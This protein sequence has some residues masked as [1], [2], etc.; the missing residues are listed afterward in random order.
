MKKKLISALCVSLA[1]VLLLTVVLFRLRK[2]YLYVNR[3]RVIVL[4]YQT[5]IGGSDAEGWAAFLEKN[6]PALPGVEVGVYRRLATGNENVTIVSEDG[7]QAIVTRLAAGQGDLLLVNNQV[8][9]ETLVPGEYLSEL[10]DVFGTRG[11]RVD[12]RLVGVDVTDQTVEGLTN[13]G[14]SSFVA[15]GQPLPLKS[16]DDKKYDRGGTLIAPRVIAVIYRG[17][18]HAEESAALLREWFS[19]E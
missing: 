15:P 12:G 3:D 14:T 8:L 18:A 6:H 13:R 10:P 1:L 19:H 5:N 16:T 4:A 7:W 9:Y 2:Q 11:I 17:A